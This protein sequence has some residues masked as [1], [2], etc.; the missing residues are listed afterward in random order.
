MA[1]QSKEINNILDGLTA[2]DELLKKLT[3]SHATQRLSSTAKQR[4]RNI[5]DIRKYL[6]KQKYVVETLEEEVNEKNDEL[7]K[8][9]KKFLELQ[10]KKE[11]IQKVDAAKT[12]EK[13]IDNLTF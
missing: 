6:A 7:R 13:Q 1:K 3:V 10:Q 11:G 12:Y 5:Q 9:N 2:I 8:I 4:R